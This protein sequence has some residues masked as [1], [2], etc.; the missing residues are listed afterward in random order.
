VDGGTASYSLPVYRFEKLII[1]DAVNSSHHPPGSIIIYNKSDILRGAVKG[2]SHDIDIYNY[3]AALEFKGEAPDEIILIG[4]VP[5][6]IDSME[7]GL[8]DQVRDA[9]PEVIEHVKAVLE[10]WSVKSR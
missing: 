8:S 4:V 5:Q 10:N 7:I 6:K 3:I 9:I 2:T 1:I